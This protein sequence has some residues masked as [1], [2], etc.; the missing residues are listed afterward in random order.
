MW[1]LLLVARVGKARGNA[2]LSPFLFQWTGIYGLNEAQIMKE[3][4]LG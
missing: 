2:D 4:G 3:L 1:C